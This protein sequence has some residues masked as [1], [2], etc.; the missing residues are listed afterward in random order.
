MEEDYS[1]NSL[2]EDKV[3]ILYTLNTIHREITDI[4]LFKIISAFV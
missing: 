4:D 3:L 2:A 1:N